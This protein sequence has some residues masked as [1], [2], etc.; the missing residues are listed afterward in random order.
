[1]S[2]RPTDRLFLARML[3]G[4]ADSKRRASGLMRAVS[5]DAA[6]AGVALAAYGYTDIPDQAQ[7]LMDEAF[8]GRAVDRVP[9]L[10]DAFWTGV[11]VPPVHPTK[12]RIVVNQPRTVTLAN[13]TEITQPL[14]L[15]H[16]GT[17]NEREMMQLKGD[18]GGSHCDDLLIFNETGVR[19][20][21]GFIAGRVAPGST[22]TVIKPGASHEG[23][24]AWLGLLSESAL[25]QALNER[26]LLRPV[27][28][29]RG[30]IDFL[31]YGVEAK[32]VAK[33]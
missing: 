28:E 20:H 33:P 32:T 24:M 6:K 29:Q 7:T 23:W 17:V 3:V 2:S 26:Y 15:I 25:F 14:A 18:I 16:G 27:I 30:E 31:V 9:L 11:T 8:Y 4:I 1:V 12:Y 19:E 10:W 21:A 13:V 5:K 22:V